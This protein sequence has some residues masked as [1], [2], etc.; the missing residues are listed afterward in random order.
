MNALRRLWASD[1]GQ[2]LVESALCLPVLILFL[3][4]VVDLGRLSQFDTILASSARAG[5]QYGSQNAT[6]AA[7][8][9]GMQTAATNDASIVNATVSSYYKCADGTA[10]PTPPPVLT[11]TGTA[12][13]NCSAN[14]KLLYV[15]VTT[16]GSFKPIL[17]LFLNTATHTH[18][19]IMQVGT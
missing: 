11:M 5:A 19:T 4:A 6:N 10:P 1:S 13:I 12:S 15:V 14:H 7:D 17:L 18:T 3:A 16:T 8:T 2:A 9:S